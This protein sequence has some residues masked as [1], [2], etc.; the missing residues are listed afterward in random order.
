MI[1]QYLFGSMRTV[2][3]QRSLIGTSAIGTDELLYINI[4]AEQ[5]LLNTVC[6]VGTV[7]TSSSRA[8]GGRWNAICCA[9]A[10]IVAQSAINDSVKIRFMEILFYLGVFVVRI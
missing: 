10:N 6:G 2:A 7:K 1:R 4:T 9:F 8:S 3:R 5:S